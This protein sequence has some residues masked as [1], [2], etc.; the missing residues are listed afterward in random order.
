MNNIFINFVR[1][2]G[3]FLEMSGTQY[4]YI[5]TEPGFKAIV[6]VIAE[7]T[8]FFYWLTHLNCMPNKAKKMKLRGKSL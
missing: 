2:A 5:H 6:F 4:L 3:S 7:G 8:V 1:E